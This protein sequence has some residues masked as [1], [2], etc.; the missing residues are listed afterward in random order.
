MPKL[1]TAHAYPL[2]AQDKLLP[3]LHQN[4]PRERKII[5]ITLLGPS[6]GEIIDIFRKIGFIVTHKSCMI[7]PIYILQS[8]II[9]VRDEA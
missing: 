8:E 3:N 5:N 9:N 1:T 4:E 2:G 6:Y 7:I